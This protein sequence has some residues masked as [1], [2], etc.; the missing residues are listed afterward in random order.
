MARVT[1]EDCVLRVPNR[2][3]L[4]M[5]AAHRA[6]DIAAGA[7]LTLDRDNDKN[8][9]VALREI[10][11]QAVAV[12]HL[13]EALVKGMQKMVEAD[14]PEEEEMDAMAAQ[15][16]AAAGAELAPKAVE[17]DAEDEEILLEGDEAEVEA[18]A[19]AEPGA[20]SGEES[21]RELG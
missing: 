6:R 21:E 3:E 4:V 2:F 9:V 13:Q 7:P 18:E 16:L 12:D 19:D 14:E 11:D 10:A 15:Q 8:P 1:V 17:E 20:E 5:L